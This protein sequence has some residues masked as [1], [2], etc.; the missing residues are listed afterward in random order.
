MITSVYTRIISAFPILKQRIKYRDSD[1]EDNSAAAF[2]TY[3]PKHNNPLYI[4]W[5]YIDI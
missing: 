4:G 5:D 2:L 3:R 1:Q